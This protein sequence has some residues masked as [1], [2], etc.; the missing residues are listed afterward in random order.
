MGVAVPLL[1]SDP[2]V[3]SDAARFDPDRFV[4]R[5]IGRSSSLRSA[6]ATGAVHGA[7]LADYE[8]RIA[9]VTI[10]G[11]V[12]L[13]LGPRYAHGRTPVSVPHNIATG[14]RRSISFDVMSDLS[15]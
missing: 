2:D 15:H 12:R 3:W 9:P 5:R 14:P 6:A 8:L 4:E 10:L 11:R 7:V 13:R 1:H